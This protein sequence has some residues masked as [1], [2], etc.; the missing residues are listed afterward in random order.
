MILGSGSPRRERILRDLGLDFLID[1]PRIKESV[2]PGEGP[3]EHVLRLALAKARDVA[4]RHERGTVLAADTIVWF[5]GRILGKPG[6]PED[7]RRVLRETRGRWHEV[8][9]GVASARASDG[10]EATGC[11]VT[12][13]LMRD[14]SEEEVDLYVESG[15]PLD[16]A[17]SYAIQDC[18][19]AVVTRV[20][21][22]FYNV[23]GLPVVRVCEIL[24]R[25][26]RA[27]ARS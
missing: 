17:G 5:D 26:E 15:E 7:A 16:K 25:M 1:A 27:A 18:G 11:E 8:Y 20:E 4:A 3:R 22:C 12:R 21:G 23:V 6:G 13:V 14:L 19:S 24:E 10:A 2:L 9:T